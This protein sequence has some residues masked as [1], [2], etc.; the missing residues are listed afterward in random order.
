MKDNLNYKTLCPLKQKEQT[1]GITYQNMHQIYVINR[2]PGPLG[3]N[4]SIMLRQPGDSGH[5]ELI[6]EDWRHSSIKA[7]L[8]KVGRDSRICHFWE[9]YK[10][11]FINHNVNPVWIAGIENENETSY[12]EVPITILYLLIIAAVSSSN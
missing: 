1:T 11:L 4:D 2:I 6:M 7:A 8:R 9:I 5:G 3:A 12:Y 10:L